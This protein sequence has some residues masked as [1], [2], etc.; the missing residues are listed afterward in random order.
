[1]KY[2]PQ[3]LQWDET[4]FLADIRVSRNLNW[5]Q[6]HIYRTLLQSCFV[7]KTRPYL[8]VDDEQLFML[9]DVQDAGM[10]LAN[11]AAVLSLFEL[12]EDEE[13][14]QVYSHP[15]ILE[16]WEKLEIWKNHGSNGG[17][18]AAANRRQ[19]SGIPPLAHS[20]PLLPP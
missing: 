20:T 15:R 17:K 16:E 11:K 2:K 9:A 14:N 3:F 13:G 18:K 12:T 5:M 8:P 6:R 19:L 4:A 1:M 10:W 7:C